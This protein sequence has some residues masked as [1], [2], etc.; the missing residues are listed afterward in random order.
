MVHNLNRTDIALS[1]IVVCVWEW[2]EEGQSRKWKVDCWEGPCASNDG[3]QPQ[4]GKLHVW[5]ITQW[6][7][8][9]LFIGDYIS[10]QEEVE[11][12]MADWNRKADIARCGGADLIVG[13]HRHRLHGIVPVRRV[14]LL[15]KIS[16]DDSILVNHSSSTR[17]TRNGKE[18]KPCWL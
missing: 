7:W 14:S 13:H 17:R 11:S 5:K 8:L 3:R 2:S 1:S 18:V 10:F 12:V 9:C 16:T 15:A 4:S 6:W